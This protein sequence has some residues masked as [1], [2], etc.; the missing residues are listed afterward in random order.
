MEMRDILHQ[1]TGISLSKSQISKDLAHVKK[2]WR[3]EQFKNYDE[4]MNIELSRIDALERS[5]WIALRNQAQPK[6]RKEIDRA[7]RKVADGD[8]EAYKMVITKTKK[9]V[10]DT[11]VNASYFAQIADCQKER[12][13]LY[14]LYAPQE[15]VKK[16]TIVKGYADVSPEDWPSVIEG[17]V[18]KVEE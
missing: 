7:R 10:E 6:H 9:V 3:A 14:G 17:E 2:A 12:R 5:I 15:S 16:V 18:I 11:A 13:K 4:L 8:E 1:E